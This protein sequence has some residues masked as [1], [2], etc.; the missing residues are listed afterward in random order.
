MMAAANRLEIGSSGFSSFLVCVLATAAGAATDDFAAEASAADDAAAG[1]G[2]VTSLVA[3]AVGDGA[4]IAAPAE[5]PTTPRAMIVIRA[6][7]PRAIL[8]RVIMP[9]AIL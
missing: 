1:V 7:V 9:R 4:Q 6:A 2:F 5:R 3:G 8:P